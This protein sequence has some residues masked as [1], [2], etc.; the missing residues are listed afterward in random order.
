MAVIVNNDFQKMLKTVYL[1]GVANCKA[2]N[3]PIIHKIKKS[4]WDGKEMKFAAQYGNG[5]NFSSDYGMLKNISQSGSLN[6]ARNLEWT[7]T[8]GY[9]VGMFDINMPEINMSSSDRGA[10]MK[11]MANKMSAMFDGFSKTAAMY[12]YGDK[13]GSIDQVPAD[14]LLTTT[15]NKWKITSAGALKMDVGTHFVIASNGTTKTA[16][17]SDSLVNTVCTVTDIDEDTITFDATNAVQV[18]EG[19]YIQLYGARNGV[20]IQG[21]EGLAE[22]IPSY[23]NRDMTTRFGT[24]YIPTS[25]RGVDR[26]VAINRLAGQFAD[27]ANHSGTT[28]KSDTLVELL[29]KTKRMGGL[30]NT[31]IVNDEDWDAIGAELGVQ[32]NLWQATNSGE[33]KNK[34]TAGLS[35][36]A[37]AFGDAFIGRTVIDP[38]CTQGKAYMLD[39]DDVEFF[40]VNDVGKVLNPVS[41]DQLGKYNI[42]SVGEQ[43]IGDEPGVKI[44]IDKLFTVMEGQAGSFGP[45]L[46]V[47]AH[48]YGAYVLRKTSSAGVA[49]I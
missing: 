41:N 43:G 32:K 29:K 23:F 20:S 36:L 2:Q 26:S 6:Q 48:I 27:V 35:Q 34:V 39:T 9:Q 38:Y 37:T 8:P 4:N 7:V 22:I 24:D 44:N 11:I 17:P 25:F 10:Y 1:S 19:D 14:T 33:D 16:L 47:A 31:I 42:E 13:Y 40:G 5:G 21:F 18:Y 45:A 12:F 3:S 49:N 15:G 28:P 46:E 30:N